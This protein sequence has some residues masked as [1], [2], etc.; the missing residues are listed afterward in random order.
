LPTTWDT[1]HARQ[2]DIRI[3]RIGHRLIQRKR[4]FRSRVRAKGKKIKCVFS[5]SI[6]NECLSTVLYPFQISEQGVFETV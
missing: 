5:L 3:Q 4:L 6:L 1:E 2:L